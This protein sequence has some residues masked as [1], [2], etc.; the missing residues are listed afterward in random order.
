MLEHY[1]QLPVRRQ[2]LPPARGRV[3][4]RSL[5]DVDQSLDRVV[6]D[7]VLD[8]EVAV[9]RRRHTAGGDGRTRDRRRGLVDVHRTRQGDVAVLRHRGLN[10]GQ[11]GRPVEVNRDARDT[12][13]DVGDHVAV[14]GPATA[15]EVDRPREGVGVPADVVRPRQRARRAVRVG[16]EDDEAVPVERGVR[17]IEGDVVA[18]VR[19]PADVAAVVD[20][21]HERRVAGRGWGRARR[22]G[23]AGAL[24][25]GGRETRGA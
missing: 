16:D 3:P 13:R 14:R 11:P 22:S 5:R 9:D 23:C 4:G 18:G 25:C 1:R 10:V 19:V 12:G 7:R 15:R 6:A 21:L 24:R 2:K 8:D 20:V 17:K